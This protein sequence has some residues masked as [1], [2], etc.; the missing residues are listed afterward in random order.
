MALH[1]AAT[2]PRP[3][4]AIVSWAGRVALPLACTHN[5]RVSVLLS[6]GLSDTVIPVS[7]L[8]LAAT[9]LRAIGCSVQTELIAGHGHSVH[10]LQ[11]ESSIRYLSSH[12]SAV[13]RA[14]S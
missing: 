14:S 7:E 4:K 9:K 10:Q 11:L 6:H 1:L 5:T 13:R 12:L 8:E 2:S 3:P